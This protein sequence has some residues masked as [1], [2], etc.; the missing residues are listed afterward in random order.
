M[1][2]CSAPWLNWYDVPVE[3]SNFDAPKTLPKIWV[4]EVMKLFF[5]KVKFIKGNT[6][7][8]TIIIIY[9][10]HF[11]KAYFARGIEN[12]LADMA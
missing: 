3:Y 4:A 10:T 1:F 9:G 2:N 11:E 7:C 6:D 8:Y 5:E 12:F